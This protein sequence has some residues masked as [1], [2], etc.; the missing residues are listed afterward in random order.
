MKR[1]T[2]V[3]IFMMIAAF[4]AADVNAQQK[5][6]KVVTDV[7]R[8]DAIEFNAPSE[9]TGTP[10]ECAV[11]MLT[12]LNL[13]VGDTP[14]FSVYELGAVEGNNV[15]VVFVSHFI[16]DD[17][18]VLGKLYRLELVN[19]ATASGTFGLDELGQ[20]FQCMNG[21]VGWRKTVCPQ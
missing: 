7:E 19:K 14:E 3:A 12:E 15:T 21:P 1:V 8:W 11:K 4:F 18:A 2:L 16:E 17:E 9:C 20:M 6:S 13:N 5:F 10:E